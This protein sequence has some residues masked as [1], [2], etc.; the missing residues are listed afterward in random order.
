MKKRHC[1]ERRGRHTSLL[2]TGSDVPKV[3][4][5]GLKKGVVCM[6]VP[7]FEEFYFVIFSSVWKCEKNAE[8]GCL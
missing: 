3:A 4:E 6:R 8:T 5:E 1:C 7:F 2:K